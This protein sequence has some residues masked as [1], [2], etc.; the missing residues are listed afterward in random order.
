MILRCRSGSLNV[1]L[2]EEKAEVCGVDPYETNVWYATQRRGLA[3][4]FF[5][6][7]SRFHD[8]DVPFGNQFDMVVGLNEHVLAHVMS[9]RLLLGRLYDLL[10]PGGYLF[11]DEKDVLLPTPQLETFVLD[12][13]RAHL[14]HLTLQTTA[15]YITGAGFELTECEIDKERTSLYKHLRVVARKP[16]TASTPVKCSPVPQQI[17]G[18][19]NVLCRL[20]VLACKAWLKNRRRV[21]HSHCRESLKRV[22]GARQAWRLSRRLF[23]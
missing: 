11:L 17:A 1:R 7:M 12:S 6:P 23:Q 8:L 18:A 10:K 9:P 5:M 16:E 19:R 22:P 3:A 2:L 21:I 13:G 20:Q 15:R 14:F 4:T